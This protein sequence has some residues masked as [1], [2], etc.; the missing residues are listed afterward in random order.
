[1][2][3]LAVVDIGS[4][5][6]KV[7]VLDRQNGREVLRASESVRLFSSA[8]GKSSLTAEVLEAGAQAVARL[9]VIAREQ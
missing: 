4:N 2:S 3:T 8:G 1:M 5:S 6:I 7:S 9:V